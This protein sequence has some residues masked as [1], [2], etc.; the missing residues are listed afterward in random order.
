MK[1]NIYGFALLFMLLS[2][3]L[4]GCS[5]K[6]DEQSVK[7]LRLA[8]TYKS[9][10]V[11]AAAD[12]EFARLVDE[13]SGGLIKIE[14]HTDGELGKKEDI[15]GKISDGEIDIAR[16]GLGE[17]GK[18]S[19]VLEKGELPFIFKNKGHMWRSLEQILGPKLDLELSLKNTKIIG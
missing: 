8:E 7:V 1:R 2:F 3:V 6:E 17:L 5:S 11:T 19:D 16:V 15:P 12:F 14:V 13:K 4:C 9:D 10:Y 18:G